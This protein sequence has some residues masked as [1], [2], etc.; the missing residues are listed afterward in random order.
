MKNQ[1]FTTS[2]IV[3]Q[4]PSDVYNAILNVRGWWS[5]LYGESFEGS[6]EKISDEFSFLAGG[7]LHYSKQKLVELEQ[8]KKVVWLVI[9]SNLTFL[10]NANEWQGTRISFELY[11]EG[12]KTKVVFTHIGLV[13]EFECYDSCAP[14]WKGYV[15][16][17]RLNLG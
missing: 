3:D 4:K 16:D 13:P 11:P 2:I 15:E 10:E 5:G 1:D 6:S 9:E 7:G 14:A 12:E 17:Q 8:D